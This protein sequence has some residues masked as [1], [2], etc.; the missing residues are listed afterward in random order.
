VIDS[1][2]SDLEAA[3]LVRLRLH[4]GGRL[5][6]WTHRLIGGIGDV[7]R[8][9]GFSHIHCPPD[10]FGVGHGVAARTLVSVVLGAPDTHKTPRGCDA[11]STAQ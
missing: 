4:T 2:P 3:I 5:S 8:C 7:I 10:Q 6:I 9:A 11:P 1:N